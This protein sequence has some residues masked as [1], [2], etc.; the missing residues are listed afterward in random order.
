VAGTVI[1]KGERIWLS[2]L[3]ANHDETEFPQPDQLILDRSPNR[4]LAFSAGVH[5]CPGAPLARLQLQVLIEEVLRQL[6]DYRLV[7]PD[8]VRISEGIPRIIRSLPVTFTP[9][10]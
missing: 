2:W 9:A 10:S 4:H 6:P 1:P 5:R 7:D 3:S 8:S